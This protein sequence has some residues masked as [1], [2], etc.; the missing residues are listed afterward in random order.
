MQKLANPLVYPPSTHLPR[1]PL[2]PPSYDS[3]P[4]LPQKTLPPP[5]LPPPDPSDPGPPALISHPAPR[6]SPQPLSAMQNVMVQAQKEGDSEVICAVPEAGVFSIVHHGPNQPP[7]WQGLAFA[8]YK[9]LKKQF[10]SMQ[11]LVPTSLLY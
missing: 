5:L 10:L 6:D 2:F 1:A 4:D 7:Q 3:S 9:E 8:Y 11:Q